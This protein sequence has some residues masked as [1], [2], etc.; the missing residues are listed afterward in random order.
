MV[1]LFAKK[2]ELNMTKEVQTILNLLGEGVVVEGDIQTT[3]DIRVDGT[4]SGTVRAG[5]RLIL[6]PTSRVTGGVHAPD[7][8]ISGMLDGDVTSPGTVT[9]RGHSRVTGT[10][11]T[12]TLIVE[13]G[14][15]FNGECRMT[16]GKGNAV[17]P[18]KIEMK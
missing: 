1:A 8:D 9:L 15:V 14:A 18:E 7:V 13:P 10:I 11:T 17:Q 16:S 5:G 6:G 2:M 3:R 12:A 4:L